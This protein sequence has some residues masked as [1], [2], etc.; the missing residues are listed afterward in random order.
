M[1][2]GFFRDLKYGARRMRRS[3]G[4]SA[5]VVLTLALGMGASTALF[6]VVYGILFRALP[7]HDPERLVVIRLERIVEG[8]QRPVRSFFPLEDLAELR[9]GT[10]AFESIA[11]Y[12]TEPSVLS[13]RGFS[14]E[15]NSASVSAAFF[16]TIG[17]PIQIGRGLTRADDH[18]SSVVLSDRLRR[19]LFGDDNAVGRTVT[20]GSRPYEIVGI[21]SPAFQIPASNTDVWLPAAGSRCC[22]FGAVARL[23]P[24]VSTTQAAADVTA[25]MPALVAKSPRVYGGTRVAVVALGDELVGDVRST[26]W[27]L[28]ASVGLLL[29]V[30]CANAATLLLGRNATRSRETAICV[31]LGASRRRLGIQ[32][33]GE[34]VLPVAAAGAIGLLLAAGVVDTL[35]ALNPTGL[36]RLDEN[37]VRIDGPAFLFALSVAAATTIVVGLLPAL[38]TGDAVG[39]IST[40]A[41]GLSAAV[42][43]RRL[44]NALVVLQLAVSVML[45]VGASLLGRSL[46][47]LIT[48]D[49]GVR[50]DHVATAAVNLSHDRRLTDAQ[51]TTL[52]DAIVQRVG[53]LPHVQAVGA[54][55]AL[56]PHASTIRLTLKRSGDTVDY[57]AT[58]VPATP[59]YFSALGVELVAGRLFSVH[60]SGTAP[61]VMIMTA[62]T[63]RRFF[64]ASDPIGRTMSLP[65]LRDGTPGQADVTLV[66]VISNVKYSG[67]QAAPDDAVYRPLRQ[68][69]WPLLFVVARTAADP[70][71]LASLLRR[72]LA[73][74][75]PLIAVSS[76]NTLDA[77]V[78]TEAAQPRFR[79][80]LLAALAMF[81]V[82]IAS[83]GLYGVVA[84]RVSQRTREFGVRMALG[85]DRANLLGLVFREGATLAGAGLVLGVTG[86]LVTTRVLRHLLYGIGPTDAISFGLA[87]SVLLL[88]AGCATYLP[89][90]R[91]ARLDPT[92]ALRVE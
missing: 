6:T 44:F 24:A 66:G 72:E 22:P 67:L 18:Q 25:I 81:S 14:E 56:P 39:M 53:A 17:G 84:H 90:R 50:T 73:A 82:G 41:A 1:P 55:A 78:A 57:E 26:L 76:T 60:D 68:Q 5:A 33:V 46:V 51:Q 3:P 20:L 10:R 42:D 4:L 83:I 85:A 34:A 47:R 43:R 30:S 71:E 69:A 70:G 19:R 75:D 31:A 27:V 74:V 54:G 92:V 16:A 65:V 35:L 8:V 52:V 15:V 89:A 80:G 21:A 63:A 32:C 79:S 87:S 61:P 38:A 64:G 62:D 9:S 77:I 11:F 7:Y 49:I 45:L 2:G 36:P 58:A 29:A 12:S 23:K 91:A 28:L 48:T 88:V 59:G 86:S 37:A 13:H 40:S